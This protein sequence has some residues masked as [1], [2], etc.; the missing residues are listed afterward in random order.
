M[1][2]KEFPHN[3]Y[4]AGSWLTSHS[5]RFWNHVWGQFRSGGH[6]SSYFK[7]FRG[8]YSNVF[9]YKWFAHLTVHSSFPFPWTF[10]SK[11]DLIVCSFIGLGI[12]DYLEGFH[13]ENLHKVSTIFFNIFFNDNLLLSARYTI[14]SPPLIL[15]TSVGLWNLLLFG[16][17]CSFQTWFSWLFYCQWTSDDCEEA[18]I[19]SCLILCHNSYSTF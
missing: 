10:S 14:W 1:K 12:L 9:S 6:V 18:G 19:L 4:S 5:Y 8:A 17:V 2:L 7:V 16:C 15:S 3:I 13:D 11:I